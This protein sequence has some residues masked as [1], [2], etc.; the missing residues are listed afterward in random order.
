MS[1]NPD[2]FH[3]HKS[4]YPDPMRKEEMSTDALVNLP[5]YLFYYELYF[6]QSDNFHTDKKSLP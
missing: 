2:R 5:R 6:F 1:L 3:I 4:F